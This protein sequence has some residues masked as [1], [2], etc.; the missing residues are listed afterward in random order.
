MC[1]CGYLHCGRSHQPSGEMIATCRN[2]GEALDMFAGSTLHSS[3]AGVD[4]VP[5]PRDGNV[6]QQFFPNLV[7][8][9]LART[10]PKQLRWRGA[11]AR[12]RLFR[13]C[14]HKGARE[15][16][17]RGSRDAQRRVSRC[18]AWDGIKRSHGGDV[19]TSS[20][21]RCRM[22]ASRRAGALP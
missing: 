9:E 14:E 11:R 5:R 6:K 7:A 13:E 16:G 2:E 22:G 8:A 12:G 17:V 10:K 3:G 4:V 20:L 19:S 21:T 15:S 18:D 1:G